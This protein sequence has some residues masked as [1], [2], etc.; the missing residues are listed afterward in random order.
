MISSNTYFTTFCNILKNYILYFETDFSKYIISR[1]F[2][3]MRTHISL[4]E[5]LSESPIEH[6]GPDHECHVT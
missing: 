3:Q 1:V 2:Q 5:L 4:M 6:Q